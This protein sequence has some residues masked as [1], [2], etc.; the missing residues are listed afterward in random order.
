MPDAPRDGREHVAGKM[1]LGDLAQGRDN[2][3]NLIRAIAA[4]AVLVSHAWPIALGPGS[5]EP[6]SELTGNSLGGWAVDVFFVISGFLI[7]ASFAR[8]P[9]AGAFLAARGLRLFPG[10]F[11]SLLLVA[12][13]MGPLVTTRPLTD[14]LTDP[15]LSLFVIRNMALVS[16]QYT[17]PGVFEANPYPA[18]VGSIWTLVH[19]VC[20]YLAVLVVGFLG[21]FRDQRRMAAALILFVLVWAIY[22]FAGEGL[23]PKIDVL[24]RLSLPFFVGVLLYVL[25]RKLPLT[26]WG[27]AGL[28]VLVVLVSGTLLSLP[29]QITALGYTVFWLAYVPRGAVLAYNRLGDYSYGIYI[30]AFPVQGLMVWL[31]GH[32]TPVT[33]IALAFPAT[34]ACAVLSWN[35]VEAPALARLRRS[36]T[37]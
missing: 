16:L 3:F 15:E 11:V 34:L 29:A 32:M 36:P 8:R 23:H 22:S 14:Y 26:F 27:I 21:A 13:V 6:L 7:A 35:L 2:N 17:L 18:V 5:V 20:C 24:H 19:E 37:V 4:T 12:F 33:N 31:L 1:L 10:L 9:H 30:Y 28:W 25:R